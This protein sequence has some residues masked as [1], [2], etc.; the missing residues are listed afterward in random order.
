MSV[1]L[2]SYFR[3][4]VY[5]PLIVASFELIW[6]KSIV[7]VVVVV[8]VWIM[9]RVSV[10][11]WRRVSEIVVELV[12]WPF[13]TWPVVTWPWQG[14]QT[15]NHLLKPPARAAEL[16]LPAHAVLAAAGTSWTRQKPRTYAD[17]GKSGV[18]A[19][20]GSPFQSNGASPAIWDRTVLPATR[21]NLQVNAHRLNPSHADRPVLDLPTL[22]GRKAEL[23]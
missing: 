20:I 7:M 19:F 22:K 10:A 3:R 18:I 8:V 5:A 15:T 23:T 2:S 16:Q 9:S 4:S 11:T 1:Q 21:Y 17:T 6:V 12:T 14:A 13:I